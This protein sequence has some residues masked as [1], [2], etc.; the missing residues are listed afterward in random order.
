[1]VQHAHGPRRAAM[2]DADE[3]FRSYERGLVSLARLG[4]LLGTDRQGA[5]EFVESRGIVVQ[6][7]PES[8]EEALRDIRTAR[9]LRSR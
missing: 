5:I 8:I 9:S 4:E 6:D 1:M 7:G 2:V 3:A